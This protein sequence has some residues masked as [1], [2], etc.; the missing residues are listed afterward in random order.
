MDKGRIF[1][2]G[3]SHEI[4]VEDNIQKV[5]SVKAFIMKNPVTGKPHLIPLRKE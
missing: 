3:L 5:Y 4:I 2:K 1:K